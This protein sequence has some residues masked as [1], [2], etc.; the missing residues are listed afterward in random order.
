MKIQRVPLDLAFDAF[1]LLYVCSF[2]LFKFIDIC[3]VP[4]YSEFSGIIR[5]CLSA[6]IWLLRFPIPCMNSRPLI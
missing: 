5:S 1:L 4:Y 2:N 6:N 3:S